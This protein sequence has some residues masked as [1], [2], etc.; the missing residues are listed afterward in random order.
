MYTIICM[1]D[2]CSWH[3]RATKMETNECLIVR[4]YARE[5]TCEVGIRQND[6][7]QAQSWFI[8]REIMHK[9]QDP[10]TI[11]RPIDSSMTCIGSMGW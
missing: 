3:L 10:R 9:F 8:G 5:H 11:Y 7:M 2:N 4:K 6:H 1:D